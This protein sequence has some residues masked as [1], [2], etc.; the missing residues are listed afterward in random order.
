MR[1][2]RQTPQTTTPYEESKLGNRNS[3]RAEGRR[4]Q[5]YWKSLTLLII[6]PWQQLTERQRRMR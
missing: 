4:R 3:S 1:Q 5:K 6:H 2:R